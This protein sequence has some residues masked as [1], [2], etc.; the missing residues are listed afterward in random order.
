MDYQ[1]IEDSVL[2]SAMDFFRQ[3][4]VG[5]FGID[6]VIIAPAETELKDIKINT[7]FMDYTFYTDDGNYLHFEFHTT[8][9]AEDLS[10]FMFY[11]ASLYYKSRRKVRTMVVYSADIS[12]V[13]T[14]IDAGSIKYEVEAFY[15]NKLDGDEKYNKLKEK[16]ESNENLTD[17]DI[18]SLTF[19]PLMNGKLTKTDR[20]IKSIELAS[21]ISQVD[22]KIK[23]LTMLFALLEK[24][25]DKESKQKFKEV[26]NM[27]DIGKM[28]LEDGIEQ[29]KKQGKIEGRIEGKYE[30][31]IKQ[32]SKKFKKIPEQYKEQLKKLPDETLEII[33]L[34]FIDMKDIKEIEEYLN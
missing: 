29:G 3:S 11:D 8:N 22:E 25:G 23:C 2:K 1:K 32:L 12:N 27:T 33:G 34:E 18:L 7:S 13:D 4:A 20:T 6:A 19:I 17:E 26:F 5:F 14:N 16:I 15:M 24:F 28:I 10:R 31:L 21:Q 9:K 30:L